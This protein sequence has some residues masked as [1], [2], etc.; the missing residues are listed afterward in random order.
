MQKLVFRNV[1]FHFGTKVGFK[2]IIISSRD[3]EH[4]KRR[5]SWGCHHRLH[6]HLKVSIRDEEAKEVERLWPIEGAG[7]H[8]IDGEPQ[9]QTKRNI[10]TDCTVVA[11]VVLY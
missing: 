10:I 6:L 3:V 9:T 2:T 11:A 7:G 4:G 8:L 1:I 5:R